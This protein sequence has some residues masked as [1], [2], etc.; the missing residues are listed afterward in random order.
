[1]S[2]EVRSWEGSIFCWDDFEEILEGW[3]VAITVSF[4]LNRDSFFACDSGFWTF[5][6]LFLCSKLTW[7]MNWLFSV[8]AFN[9]FRGST[10]PTFFLIRFSL[11]LLAIAASLNS[12]ADPKENS[13]ITCPKS[14]NKEERK[15]CEFSRPRVHPTSFRYQLN[16]LD[17]QLTWWSAPVPLR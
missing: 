1:M 17:L 7:N 6:W 11:P 16:C 2:F 10:A 15:K 3:K 4:E 5:D 13:L 8:W 12:E 9:P 14:W